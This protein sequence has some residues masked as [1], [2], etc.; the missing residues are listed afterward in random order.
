[1][2]LPMN[3]TIRTAWVL[4]I[5]F[6][7]HFNASAEGWIRNK[8][9][10]LLSRGLGLTQI[11]ILPSK[12]SPNVSSSPVGI[13]L[14][15]STEHKVSRCVGI[16]IQTGLNIFMKM[17]FKAEQKSFELSTAYAIPIGGRILFH[18]LEELY[19]PGYCRY[20]VYYGIQ[21]G[22]GPVFEAGNKP[23]WFAYAG[24]VTGVRYRF[25]KL[26][27]FGEFGY[28]ANFFNCGVTF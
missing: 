4:L 6:L 19:V 8:K 10:I 28:G 15:V 9:K 13:S 26:S 18:L 3:Q 2:P 21:F 22:G 1:M 24:P 23:R 11:F 14:N 7:L 17:N 5:L 12:F 20:D 27:L 16:G 25:Y